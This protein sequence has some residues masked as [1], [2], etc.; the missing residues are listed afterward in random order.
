MAAARQLALPDVDAEGEGQAGAGNE[1]SRTLAEIE[2]VETQLEVLMSAANNDLSLSETR[3][4]ADDATDSETHRQ[5]NEALRHEI[6][7]LRG[8]LAKQ[9]DPHVDA[10]PAKRTPQG[11]AWLD[12]APAVRRS[13]LVRIL[14]GRTGGSLIL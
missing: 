7:K 6:S 2:Q 13:R 3:R 8:E 4:G 1:L 14:P 5:D 12:K 11:F 10:P 9:P